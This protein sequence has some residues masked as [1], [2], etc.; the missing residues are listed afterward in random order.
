MRVTLLSSDMS[1]NALVRTYL[2]AEI[3]ARDFEVELIGTKLGKEIWRPAL[4]GKFHFQAVPGARWPM[5][6]LSV[7]TL[8]RHRSRLQ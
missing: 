2:L 3:L 5:Y 6:A 1:S 4:T 7:R 8:L